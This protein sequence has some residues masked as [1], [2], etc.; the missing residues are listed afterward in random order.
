MGN[1][2]Y[3][4]KHGADTTINVFLKKHL[5]IKNKN[6]LEWQAVCPFHNDTQPSLSINIRKGVYICYA[7]GAKGNLKTLA[8]HFD[9]TAPMLPESSLDE[10]METLSELSRIAN[11]TRRAEV[12]IKYPAHF[13]GNDTAKQYWCSERGL[14]ETQFAKYQL[15]FDTV[16]NESII[17]INDIN[18]RC[19]GMIRRT[20]D[21]EKLGAGYPKYRYPK[22][23]KISHCLYGIGEA[24]EAFYRP[25]PSEDPL[26]QSV[27]VICEGALDAISVFGKFTITGALI[28]ES[29]SQ[30][31]YK[32]FRCAGVAVLGARISEVQASELKNIAPNY[33]IIATDN[34]RAGRLAAIQ[35][36]RQIKPMALGCFVHTL[37]WNMN[38]P[39][40]MAELSRTERF[41]KI[42]RCLGSTVVSADIQP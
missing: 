30:P 35:I 8:K 4:D 24:L 22:G 6:G 40:D 19:R 28:P 27:L 14:T 21:K 15:G 1:F 33:I 38:E 11:T 36:E 18:G 31:H 2:R 16:E 9:D 29:E 7:C 41:R 42:A 5:N 12:G 20:V 23:F 37:T 25:K 32:H 39:K 10:V 26:A 34:D 13:N 3:I 17:P